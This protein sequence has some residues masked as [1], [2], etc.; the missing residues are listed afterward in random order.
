MTV[1]AFILL[2]YS[3]HNISTVNPQEKKRHRNIGRGLGEYVNWIELAQ[4]GLKWRAFVFV[5][6]NLVP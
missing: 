3:S 5:A 4:D 1:L 6:I 2:P